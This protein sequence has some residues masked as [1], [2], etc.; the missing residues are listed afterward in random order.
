MQQA[1]PPGQALGG[2][3]VRREGGRGRQRERIGGIVALADCRMRAKLRK[4]V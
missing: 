2:E 3:E 1:G 4:K